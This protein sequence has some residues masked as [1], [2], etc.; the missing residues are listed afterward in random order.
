MAS[1]HLSSIDDE[2][3]V[4]D[5]DST[6]YYIRLRGRFTQNDYV[7]ISYTSFVNHQ[8]SNGESVKKLNGNINGR[9]MFFTVRSNLV[10]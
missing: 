7:A 3:R 2:Q 10:S 9:M 1:I 5:S 6:G 4:V 8:T